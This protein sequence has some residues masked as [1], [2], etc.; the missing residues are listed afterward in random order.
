[1]V[2]FRQEAISGLELTSRDDNKTIVSEILKRVDQLIKKGD[3]ERALAEIA[4]AKEV[5]PRN[6]YTLALEER[7]LLMKT[8]LPPKDNASSRSAGTRIS[9]S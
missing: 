6:A 4:H 7:I 3:L 5:E 9:R 8:N 2:K 1:M